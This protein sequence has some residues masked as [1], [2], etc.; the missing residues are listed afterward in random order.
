MKNVKILD[1]TLRDGGYINNWEFG[2]NTIK[3][4]ISK[5]IQSK[6]DIIE[7]G[8]LIN[9]HFNNNFSRFDSIS[10]PLS[11][12]GENIKKSLFVVML[13]VGDGDIDL[14]KIA[15][16]SEMSIAG[17]RLSFNHNN[18][19]KA[20]K[21]AQKIK[22]KGYKIFLQPMKTSDYKDEDLIKLIKNVNDLSPYAFYI[23]DTFGSMYQNDLL[24]LF[25]LID[26]NLKEDIKIGFH[27][28]NNLQLSFSNAQVLM[29]LKTKRE[30]II[31]SSVFGMGR[32]AGNLATELLARYINDNVQNK[33]EITP[34]LNIFDEYLSNIYTKTPWGYSLPHF[35][36]A[37]HNCHPNYSTYLLNKQTIS[38]ETINILLN[39]IPKKEKGVYNKDL[40]ENLYLNYQKHKVNDNKTKELLSERFKDKK[41]LILAPG[42]TLL[43]EKDKISDFIGSEKPIT[44]S[45]NFAHKAC[46]YMFMS[47][48]KR[49]KKII[50]NSHEQKPVILTSNITQE[51]KENLFVLDYGSLIL[52]DYMVSD[53]AGL[54]LIKFLTKIGVKNVTLA[55]FDGFD[56]NK[57]KNYFDT[58]LINNIEAEELI[59]KNNAMEE[60]LNK[61]SKTIKIEY[62]TTSLYNKIR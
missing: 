18:I 53:N 29:N 31:D 57:E 35:L 49:F 8:F 14:D 38:V 17:I 32:G 54:M 11:V 16:S 61:L 47:N 24:R 55:G 12:I 34:L 19:E 4:I 60:V 2:E 43:S 41:I 33:Y 3:A 59:K 1:C 44:I 26:N 15:D 45:V 30:I 27:S 7:C 10:K 25:Y 28:H 51:E 5:L 52:D 48:L 13:D 37:T 21:I 6:V 50:Y 20:I 62:L 9:K 40:I 23:V 36:S 56:P 39:K 42:E 22:T 46:D 58:K